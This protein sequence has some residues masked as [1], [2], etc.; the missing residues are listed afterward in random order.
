M[1]MLK[2]Q[3]FPGAMPLDPH[4]GTVPGSRSPRS[5]AT[6]GLPPPPPLQAPP[7]DPALIRN[8]LRISLGRRPC[9]AYSCVKYTFLHLSN[10]LLASVT[11][12]LKPVR[13]YGSR[14]TWSA[15]SLSIRI[16]NKSSTMNMCLPEKQLYF[17][18]S[19]FINV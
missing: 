3:E 11:I 14:F 2:I 4:R 19:N 13:Y 6:E 10:I 15:C 12:I 1:S 8:V 18:F 16:S 5:A 17:H 7:L 9:R